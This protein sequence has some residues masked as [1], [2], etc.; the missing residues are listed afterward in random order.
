MS[1]KNRIFDQKRLYDRK[2]N[3]SFSSINY[4][5]NYQKKHWKTKYIIFKCRQRRKTSGDIFRNKTCYS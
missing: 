2:K 4:S 1:I 3:M 5:V